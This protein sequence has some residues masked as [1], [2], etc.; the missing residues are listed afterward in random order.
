MWF[1]CGLGGGGAQPMGQVRGDDFS[2][3][4]EFLPTDCGTVLKKN[5]LARLYLEI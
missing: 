1:V 4:G 5:F 3:A 2:A